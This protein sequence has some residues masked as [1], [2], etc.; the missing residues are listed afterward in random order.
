[1]VG[2]ADIPVGTYSHTTARAAVF[3][4]AWC[5]T[6]GAYDGDRWTYRHPEAGPT[7]P[8]EERLAARRADAVEAIDAAFGGPPEVIPGEWPGPGPDPLTYHP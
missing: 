4:C 1:M 3:W 5:G 6:L 7:Q 8:A 2:V